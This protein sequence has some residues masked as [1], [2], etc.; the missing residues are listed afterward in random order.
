MYAKIEE[1]CNTH[2]QITSSWENKCQYYLGTKIVMIGPTLFLNRNSSHCLHTGSCNALHTLIMK[3][4]T[5][6][7]AFCDRDFT[8]AHMQYTILRKRIHIA[9]PPKVLQLP[10]F[11]EQYG[12]KMVWK[13]SQEMPMLVRHLTG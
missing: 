9:F 8:C 11:A 10:I 3:K 5:A 12:W 2:A 6:T 13:A 7:Y 4:C 1:P